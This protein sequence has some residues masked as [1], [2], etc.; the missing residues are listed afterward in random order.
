LTIVKLKDGRDLSLDF[1]LEALIAAEAAYGQP[2]AKLMFDASEGFI[3]AV[4]ALIYGALRAKH[5]GI[6]LTEAGEI[7]RS[8][9]AAI[10]KAL[11]EATKAPKAKKV[12]K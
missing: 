7:W 1:G 3:G 2:A 12:K 5:P 4:R 10:E 11:A 6:T 8:D 9:K